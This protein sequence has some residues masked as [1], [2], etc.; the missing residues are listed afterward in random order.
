MNS[1]LSSYQWTAPDQGR[2]QCDSG[3]LFLQKLCEYAKKGTSYNMATQQV[4]NC[5]LAIPPLSY[6]PK[7]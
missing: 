4:F 1:E 2:I 3:C 5:L 7:H 6:Q